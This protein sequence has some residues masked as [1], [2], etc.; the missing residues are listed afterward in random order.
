L[1]GEIRDEETADAALR[2][3]QTGHLVLSTLHTNDAVR[4]ISRLMMLKM[5]PSLIAGSL[6]GALSQ[7]LVR[8]LCENCRHEAPPDER[9][10]RIFGLPEGKTFFKAEGCEACG[11][12]GFTGRM[13]VYELFVPD[14]EMADRIASEQPVHVIR[15]RAVEKGMKTL[16]G[17]AMEKARAGM[18]SLSEIRRVVPYRIIVSERE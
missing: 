11:H 16:L 7:R 17:D 9:E 18:I 15:T 2:A 3:A 13:G 4:T 1:I 12:T 5:D 14:E 8:R 6:L 10:R